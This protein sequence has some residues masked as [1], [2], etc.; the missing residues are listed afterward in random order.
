M[1][2]YDFIYYKL[3]QASRFNDMDKM[4]VIITQQLT[5]CLRG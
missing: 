3:L 2:N 4:M 1:R 5:I